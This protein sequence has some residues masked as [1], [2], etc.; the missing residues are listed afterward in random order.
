MVALE[1]M[2]RARPVIAASIGGLEDLVRDGETGL[3]VRPGTPTRSRRRCSPWPP[4]RRA[5]P[6]W[7]GKRAAAR[8]SASPRP[9][10]PSGRRRST[11]TS[12]PAPAP[13]RGRPQPTRR[14]ARP[15]A[16][17]QLV[18]SGGSTRGP[19]AGGVDV[20]FAARARACRGTRAGGR[21]RRGRP[22]A[23]GAAARAR[24]RRKSPRSAPPSSSSS[25]S[26]RSS[27]RNQRSSGTP[28]PVFAAAAISGGRSAAN[29]RLSAA[30]P[31][32]RL[33]RQR[34]PE[35]DDAVVEERRA[36]LER[37]RHRREVR[38]RQQV[39]RQVRLDVDD[40]QVGAGGQLASRVACARASSVHSR[41]RSS[42]GKTS[43]RRA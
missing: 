3:L 35:L 28:K 17:V 10:A 9:A 43:T 26:G 41:R 2:E 31:D 23:R 4:T 27:S 33:G 32:A 15:L 34:Q 13:P 25:A 19:A 16:S 18:G 14:S 30:L 11:A 39:A 29:A 42:S 7:A 36:Q 22:R 21:G 1:A 8:S 12:S 24:L 37:D 38:L 40:P 5:R 20:A 6:R